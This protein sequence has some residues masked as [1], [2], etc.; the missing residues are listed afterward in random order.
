MLKSTLLRLMFRG[1]IVRCNRDSDPINR[2]NLPNPAA[3][4]EFQECPENIT[5]IRT[6]LT[7][8]LSALRECSTMRQPFSK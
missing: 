2:C 4:T 8:A 6:Q 3:L 5:Q 7:A 1:I